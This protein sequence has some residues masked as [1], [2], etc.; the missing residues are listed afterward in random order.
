MVYLWFQKYTRKWEF[1]I[2]LKMLIHDVCTSSCNCSLQLLLLTL[3]YV[4]CHQW[5]NELFLT[6]HWL[7]KKQNIWGRKGVWRPE[8]IPISMKRWRQQFQPLGGVGEWK[9]CYESY[10]N[11]CI[12]EQTKTQRKMPLFY[13]LYAPRIRSHFVHCTLE[14]G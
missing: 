7:C 2:M 10:W 9:T 1:S 13:Y 11:I 4:E 5:I 12:D 8:N 3:H 6:D 14:V